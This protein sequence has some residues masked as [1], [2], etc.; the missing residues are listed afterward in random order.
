MNHRLILNENSHYQ[1]IKQ[2]NPYL[3]KM[4]VLVLALT[5]FSFRDCCSHENLPYK[6]NSL[7][8]VPHPITDQCGRSVAIW[9][10][11]ETTPV[12]HCNSRT[13]CELSHS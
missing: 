4:K 2:T 7:P 6:L 5:L 3:F 8:N 9:T 11:A 1:T 10:Q 12:G 13:P